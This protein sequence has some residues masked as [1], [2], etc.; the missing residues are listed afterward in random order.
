MQRFFWKIRG[1][2]CFW[3]NFRIVCCH[4]NFQVNATWSVMKRPEDKDTHA[5]V[6]SDTNGAPELSLT[7]FEKPDFQRRRHCFPET[8]WILQ[9]KSW[10]REGRRK[11]KK[12]T[13]FSYRSDANCF[14]KYRNLGPWPVNDMLTHPV[15]ECAIHVSHLLSRAGRFLPLPRQPLLALFGCSLEWTSIYFNR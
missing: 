3:R 11:G 12:S 6:D 7:D 8:S 14:P 15:I 10:T 5:R 1:K 2:M 9:S 4:K 13:I